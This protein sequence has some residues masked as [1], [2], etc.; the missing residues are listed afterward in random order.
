MICKF[1]YN[2]QIKIVEMEKKKFIF[3]YYIGME[4][5]IPKNEIP[6]HILMFILLG[7]DVS[8]SNSMMEWNDTINLQTLLIF[9][10]SL[11]AS[12][13]LIKGKIP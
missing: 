2:V 4:W 12:K 7:R 5:N 13:L 3:V 11:L 6:W 9:I 10:Q 8:F 1:E